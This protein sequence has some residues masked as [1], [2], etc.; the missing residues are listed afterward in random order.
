MWQGPQPRAL[1][2][3]QL[4]VA[5]LTRPLLLRA[6]QIG[7]F[8]LCYFRLCPDLLNGFFTIHEE[9]ILLGQG[10]QQENR[11]MIYDAAHPAARLLAELASSADEGNRL[12]L[13]ARML[14]LV[15][16]ALER[17]LEQAPA[18]PDRRADASTRFRE[19]MTGLPAAE[20]QNFSVRELAER[21]R[22]SERHFTRLFR[23]HFGFSVRA[24]Q[25]EMRLQRAAQML[26]D[27]D[28]KI[29]YVAI[30]SGFRHLGL[31]NALFKKRFGM[32]PTEWRQGSA[33]EIRK[34]RPVRLP[35][36]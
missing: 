10:V 16:A 36:N 7:E 2:T 28:E 20:I 31:F 33:R 29:L 19:L 5:R 34:R 9:N 15:A 21:C 35:G 18:A 30:E 32:T 11:A 14:T 4:V 3:G 17:D 6:S 13:R 8:R 23:E 26:Q 22:C 12:A 1:D 25:T 27:S 24:K